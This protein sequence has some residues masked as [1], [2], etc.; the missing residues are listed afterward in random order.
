MIDINDNEPEFSNLI[1]MGEVLES[2]KVDTS[3]VK[4]TATDED[5]DKKLIYTF[6][7]AGNLVSLRKFKINPHNGEHLVLPAIDL[8]SSRGVW[9]KT[10]YVKVPNRVKFWSFMA[11]VVFF[12]CWLIHPPNALPLPI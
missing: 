9:I 10:Y 5:E 6:S 4:V 11:I 8:Q 3:V 7:S 1:Y 12:S 2:A